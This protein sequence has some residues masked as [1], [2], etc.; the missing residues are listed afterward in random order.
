MVSTQWH[1]LE[2]LIMFDSIL[3]Q[4]L[5]SKMNREKVQVLDVREGFETSKGHIKGAVLLPLT[6][7]K[8]AD[9]VLNKDE[10]YYVVCHSGGR[11]TRAAK[12]LSKKGYKMVNVLGGMS[13]Y[14]GPLS[15]E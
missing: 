14:K 7:L 6:G 13:A 11:S 10:T 9:E 8:A 2:V 3:M 12:K 4:E 1:Y 5:Q 15:H